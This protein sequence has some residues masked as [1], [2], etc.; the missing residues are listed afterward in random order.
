[1]AKGYKCP[2]CGHIN[3]IQEDSWEDKFTESL[4]ENLGKAVLVGAATLL[5]GGIFGVLLGTYFYG[6]SV[7]KYF[8]GTKITCGNKNCGRDFKVIIN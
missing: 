2:H 6:E 5:T 1:M 4:P 7:V 3:V 8:D